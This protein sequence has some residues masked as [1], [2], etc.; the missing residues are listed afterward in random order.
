[1]KEVTPEFV[2]L[3]FKYY[4]AIKMLTYITNDYCRVCKDY[5]PDLKANG[6]ERCVTIDA[7]RKVI[8]DK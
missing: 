5:N 1:M 4:K 2:K 6:C 3:A 7:C 8:G